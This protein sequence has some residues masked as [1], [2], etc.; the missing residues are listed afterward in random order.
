VRLGGLGRRF[1]KGFEVVL[2]PRLRVYVMHARYPLLDDMLALLYA[3]PQGYVEVGV[4]VF[5]RPPLCTTT[6]PDSYA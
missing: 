1:D 3:H 6:Q 5:T 2:S 4:V